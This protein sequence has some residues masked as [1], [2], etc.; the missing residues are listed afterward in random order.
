MSV[1]AIIKDGKVVDTSASTLS[2]STTTKK[3]NDSLD[4]EAFL[5]LLVAQMQYQD[6]LEPMSNTE[7]V[8]QLAT[9]SELEAMTNLND[10][11]GLSRAAELVGK[12]VIVKTTSETTGESYMLQG[13]VDYV[14]MENGKAYLAIG[15]GLYSIEDLDSIVSD[16][17]WDKVQENAGANPDI[18][19]TDVNEV[20]SMISALPD[21]ENVTLDDEEDVVAA[22]AAY[23]A[24]PEKEKNAIV[25]DSLYKLI[26][27]E[28]A[29][30]KLKAAAN[31]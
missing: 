6:P 14:V 20:L 15:E 24:L 7:Y 16:E 12:N 31:Q 1:S 8:A 27:V 3:A 10:S 4:K 18:E 5:Q 28:A 22:R 23:D 17:Y 19:I 30:A 29:L 13:V 11:M 21:S 9:F 25:D 26:K 2:D